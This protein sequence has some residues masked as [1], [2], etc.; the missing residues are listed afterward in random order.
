[1]LCCN[2]GLLFAYICGGYLDYFTVPYLILPFSA[3]F[4]LLFTRYP[5]SPSSL[6]KRKLFNVSRCTLLFFFLQKLNKSSLKEA[7][8]SFL[9]YRSI[10]KY[11][12]E[13]KTKFE[14]HMRMFHDDKV[15]LSF[16][17]FGKSLDHINTQFTH[18]LPSCSLKVIKKSNSLRHHP[19]GSEP[20]LWLFC[21]YYLFSYDIPAV[22]IEF[23]TH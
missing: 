3:A 7:E 9:F 22:W 15:E 6:I 4:I 16:Q 13:S 8:K 20:I 18:V 21:T 1:M 10:D 17:D 11:S 23:V 2:T 19:D 12:R 14:D 5:D